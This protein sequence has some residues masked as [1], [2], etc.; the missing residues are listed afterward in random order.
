M[1]RAVEIVTR[2]VYALSG[3][4]LLT[5]GFTVIA[6]GTGVL[7]EWVHDSIFEMGHGDP[8]T[9]HLIQETG[10][11]WVLVGMLFVWFARHYEHSL[12]FH[13]AVVFFLVLDAWVHWFTAFGTFE[14]EPRAVINAIPLF[15][16]LVL[17]LLRLRESGPQTQAARG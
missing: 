2:G 6:L 13:W 10:T 7:P 12:K 8:F 15:V 16:Y 9:M 17:G 1:Q 4:T 5:M 14:H 11:L 3:A